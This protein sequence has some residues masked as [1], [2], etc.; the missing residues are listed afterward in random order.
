MMARQEAGRSAGSGNAPEDRRLLLER[1]D[2]AAKCRTVIFLL[3]GLARTVQQDLAVSVGNDQVTH[4]DLGSALDQATANEKDTRI[5]LR[6][7]QAVSYGDL[8][9]VM[10]LLR[11]AGYLKIAWLV[12]KGRDLLKRGW[13]RRERTR[14]YCM[15]TAV[16]A[17]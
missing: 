7:D 10:N 11:M 5:F 9:N 3:C 12:L 4:S 17:A 1:S 13:R 16:G 8:M 15:V 14:R 6:A 2:N